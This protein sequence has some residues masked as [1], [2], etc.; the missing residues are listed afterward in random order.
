MKIV[1]GAQGNGGCAGQNGHFDQ[2]CEGPR[3]VIDQVSE[4][5]NVYAR[6]G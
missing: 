2:A 3:F 1:L 4:D 6:E 5:A